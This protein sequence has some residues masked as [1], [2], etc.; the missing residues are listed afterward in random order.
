MVSQLRRSRRGR[1]LR[2]SGSAPPKTVTATGL[3]QSRLA[4]ARSSWARERCQASS[5]SVRGPIANTATG[6]AASSRRWRLRN[7]W[8]SRCQRP[9]YNGAPS[10]TRSYPATD[11]PTALA[12]SSVTCAPRSRKATATASA[13]CRVEQ[14]LVAYATSTFTRYLLEPT[15]DRL[16]HA[17]TEPLVLTLTTGFQLG[18]ST[19]LD[20][21]ISG[22]W[23]PH[24]ARGQASAD[25]QRW[26]KPSRRRLCASR[27][28]GFRGTRY[29]ACSVFRCLPK[30][31]AMR[32]R[33]SCADGS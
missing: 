28:R 8:A 2:P 22:H 32:R 26:G 29:D 3:S 10:T 20:S 7:R 4:R 24:L 1:L 16:W 23:R 6:T 14:F 5:V 17:A 25:E 13:T 30:K 11:S 27:P 18:L 12:G 19:C 31:A 15:L 21:R 33:A 9:E